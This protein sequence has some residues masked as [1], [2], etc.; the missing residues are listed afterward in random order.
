[1]NRFFSLLLCVG[2][3]FTA[4]TCVNNYPATEPYVPPSQPGTLPGLPGQPTNPASKRL[5]LTNDKVRLGIDLNAGGAITYL[6]EGGSNENMVNNSDLGRQIQ[7]SIYSGP[8]YYEVNG[9]SPVEK[10]K[11]LGWN[12]VQT[13]DYY[14]NPS[15]IS[16]YQQTEN[17]IYVKST[18]LIWPLLNEPADC[19]ME[20]WY[21][22]QNN[23]VK[24]RCRITVNRMDTTQYEARTQETPCVYLNGPW[25]RMIT[26]D[27]LNPFTNAP[28]SEYRDRDMLTRFGSENWIA[29]LNDKGRGVGLYRPNEFR[30]RT[31]GFGQAGIGGENNESSGYLNSDSFIL[32]DHNGQYEYEYILVVGA[33]ADIRQFAYSQPRPATRPDYRFVQDRQGW[34]YYNAHDTGW[35]IRNELNIRL[36]RAEATKEN[37]GIKSPLVFWRAADV[38]RLYINAA[39]QTKA[40]SIRLAWRRPGE[41]DI[42]DIPTRSVDIPIIGDGQYRVYEVNMNGL[43]GW[44]GIITQI[45]FMYAPGQLQFEKGSTFRLRSVTATRP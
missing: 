12:P 11:Y 16:S 21:E 20:H 4:F 18:P 35:P 2:V 40:T 44:D 30:Y 42:Y 14:N 38:P 19:Q 25:Y 28:T 39:F 32:I 23:T 3:S 41:V 33:L 7:T 15:R 26:Y 17:Q 27:G 22:I 8:I 5:F 10:W 24:V 37:I 6:A 29:L 45:Q 34:Y 36:Q 9:K 31:A 13:G 1:M 43:S